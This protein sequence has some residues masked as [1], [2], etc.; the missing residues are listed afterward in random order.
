MHRVLHAYIVA[1][2]GPAFNALVVR[3]Y[4]FE[5]LAPGG[6]SASLVVGANE[7]MLD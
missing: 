5:I 6:E 3:V 2:Q 4:K 7:T 1:R